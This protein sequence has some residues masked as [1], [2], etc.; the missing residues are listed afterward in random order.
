[1]GRKKGRIIP[2]RKKRL[3]SANARLHIVSRKR[4][5]HWTN[6]RD[7]NDEEFSNGFH[8]KQSGDHRVALPQHLNYHNIGTFN[9]V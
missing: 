2:A 3:N 7:K 6:E 5:T 4:K 9:R 8:D 1:M